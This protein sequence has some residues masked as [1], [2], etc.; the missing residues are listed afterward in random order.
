MRPA[1][2]PSR[3]F[4][5]WDVAGRWKKGESGNPRGRAVERDRRIW[6]KALEAAAL[7]MTPEGKTKLEAI[8][9]ATVQAALDGDMAA[10]K[11]IAE[12]LEGKVAAPIDL[13]SDVPFVINIHSGAHR[14]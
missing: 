1:G 9:E 2:E 7:A 13:P 14:E 11:E 8:A 6:S 10:V 4:V 3:F 5:G 12:R